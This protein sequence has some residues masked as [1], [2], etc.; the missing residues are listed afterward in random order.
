M[1]DVLLAVSL[2]LLTSVL[3][4][5]ANRW[6]ALAWI[7]LVPLGCAMALSPPGAA[8]VAGA[9]APVFVVAPTL[10]TSTLRRL[11]LLGTSL[12]MV[13]W[14]ALAAAIAHVWP[15]GEV[16]WALL[17]VPLFVVLS[18]LPLRLVGAPRS[19]NNPLAR[20]QENW[21]PVVHIARLGSDLVVTATLGLCSG[22]V[23]V[24]LLQMAGFGEGSGGSWFTAALAT[25]V[26]SL[27][28][29]YGHMS[30]RRVKAT[31]AERAKLR[32][33]AVVYDGAPPTKKH[34]GMWPHRSAEYAEVNA[35]IERYGAA[36][37]EALG[38]GAEV[39]VLP[40]VAVRVSRDS[41]KVWIG[42]V[43]KWA[44]QHGVV[45][46]APYFDVE[47]SGNELVMV[48]APGV[49]ARYSKQHPAPIEAKRLERM[50]PG[51]VNV[52][53]HAVSTVICVDLD[54]N[55][56]ITSV[57][58][59]GG[60]LT[61]PSNDW[62]GYDEL[63]HRTAVWAAVM[64]GTSVLRSTAHGISAAFDGAGHVLAA[65]SSLGDVRRVVLVV[66][67]PV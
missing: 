57:A 61:V 20:T 38:Q 13:T 17:A 49:L 37:K 36:V 55:D 3:M 15:D 39:V 34:D 35:A 14:A 46:V 53:G 47:R 10:P 48:G 44:D 16:T 56:W 2:G 65:K 21:L 40:E 23:T 8:A 25:V 58:Q 66:D 45:I 4:L 59:R 52:G 33:A 27:L 7:A 29:G 54:Y 41:L 18:V 19:A 51:E 30:Y 60:V 1:T 67:V 31:L 12:N 28:I 43:T 11:L 64:S 42:A 22:I 24:L 32:V 26:L 62:P 63:H 5:W 9:V 50:L 6:A